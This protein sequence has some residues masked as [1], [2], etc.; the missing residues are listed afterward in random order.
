[1]F[2]VRMRLC[3]PWP[4]VASLGSVPGRLPQSTRLFVRMELPN[5]APGHY[6]DNVNPHIPRSYVRDRAV[7]TVQSEVGALTSSA[8]LS[9][10]IWRQLTCR[11]SPAGTR[12]F[13]VLLPSQ[14]QR[15]EPPGRRFAHG[16]RR[17]Q[18]I[19]LRS[20]QPGISPYRWGT[21]RQTGI[22]SG[23]AAAALLSDTPPPQ[24]VDTPRRS[25]E[26]SVACVQHL[27]Q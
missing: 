2:P 18:S 25:A 22:C 14:G 9:K 4:I 17:C 13:A 19:N 20:T 10:C 21:I 5:G 23:R 26:C 7:R 3:M 27:F 24:K 8:G 12:P 1:M 11:Q 16:G 15:S 6:R